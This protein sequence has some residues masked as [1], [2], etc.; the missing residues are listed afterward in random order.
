MNPVRE[1]KKD[2]DDVYGV[3]LDSVRGFDL[4]VDDHNKINAGVSVEELRR[5]K[6]FYGVGN[7]NSKDAYVLHQTN[8]YDYKA[9]NEKNGRNRL[10]LANQSIVQIYQYW[11]DLYREEIAK[12]L[13][14]EKSEFKAPIFGDFRL[15]RNSII[16][17]H[18][19]ATSDVVKCEIL[20]W[21]KPGERISVDNKM[22]ENAIYHVKITLDEFEKL[23]SA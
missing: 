20:K 22:F 6:L 4:I 11:E 18:G 13:N 19:I 23:I 14:I 10:V 2:I 5:R 7:P 8:Q 3:Y 9:R 1:F 12:L 15:L 17:N 16:H 21:F